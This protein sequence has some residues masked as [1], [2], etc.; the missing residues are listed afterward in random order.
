MRFLYLSLSVF[1]RVLTFRDISSQSP[2]NREDISV[3]Y[4]VISLQLNIFQLLPDLLDTVYIECKIWEIY[5][6]DLWY[7]YLGRD[8]AYRKAD[9]SGNV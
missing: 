3:K 9:G 1:F 7:S 8:A 5:V 4:P 6:T 2:L